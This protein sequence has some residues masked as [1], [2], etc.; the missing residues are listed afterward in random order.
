M[1]DGSGCGMPAR[2]LCTD[3]RANGRTGGRAMSQGVGA[4]P[5]ARPWTART[6]GKVMVYE[7]GH[8]LDLCHSVESDGTQD[9]LDDTDENNRMYFRALTGTSTS[10][11]PSQNQTM[12][13]HIQLF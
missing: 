8:V 9:N 12:R 4:T 3:P 5:A 1:M 11:S 7:V 6:L 2:A 13:A 10:F